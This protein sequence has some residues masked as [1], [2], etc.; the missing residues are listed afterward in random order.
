MGHDNG[1]GAEY[2]RQWFATSTK[3]EGPDF[4]Q[5]LLLFNPVT[6]GW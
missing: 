4:H 2:Y 5:G 6:G 1:Q 3:A